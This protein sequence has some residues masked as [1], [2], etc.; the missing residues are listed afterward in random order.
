MEKACCCEKR[1]TLVQRLCRAPLKGMEAEHGVSGMATGSPAL[2]V[3]MGH[4]YFD[5][6]EAF[7][8]AFGPHLNE[9]V[10]DTPNYTNIEPSIQI[11]EVR[12]QASIEPRGTTRDHPRRV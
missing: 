4:L 12:L 3:A 9:I 10:S 6:A 2:F 8:S 1:M 7:Q 5:S 11:S